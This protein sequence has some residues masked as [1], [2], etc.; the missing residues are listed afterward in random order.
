M[1]PI[2]HADR[3]REHAR[4]AYVEPA[5]QRHE[6]SLRIVASHKFLDTNNLVLEKSEGP[7]S[8]MSTTMAF[9]YRFRDKPHSANDEPAPWP[10]L[11]LRGI[12]KHVFSDLGG[13]ETFIRAERERF[14]GSG[15][16]QRAGFTGTAC[17]LA[18]RPPALRPTYRH[19]V[20]T[21]GELIRA[22]QKVGRHPPRQRGAFR[23]RP[24]PDQ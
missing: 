11:R 13:G 8:G 23:Y 18:G 24:L 1:L 3:V 5:K 21:V 22:G 19:S 4:L 12:A 7:P 9:T 16:D 15:E 10:F 6:S 2:T 20:F 14:S 17:V